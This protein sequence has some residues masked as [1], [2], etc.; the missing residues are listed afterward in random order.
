MKWYFSEPAKDLIKNILQTD[1]KKRLSLN[2]IKNH[3]WTTSGC[4]KVSVYDGI[5][6]GE[7]PIPVI[8]EYKDKIKPLLDQQVEP[9]V[10]NFGLIDD[11][12]SKNRHNSITTTYYLLIKKK[13]M[14]TEFDEFFQKATDEKIQME[15][16]EIDEGSFLGS[17]SNKSCMKTFES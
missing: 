16:D 12:I 3:K 1:P 11:Y 9:D 13:Q 4:P 7:D 14:K 6:V 17:S 2:S 10:I 5:I 15:A 8:N